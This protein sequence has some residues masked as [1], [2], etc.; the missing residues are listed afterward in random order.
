MA[1]PPIFQQSWS[2][3]ANKLFRVGTFE[4]NRWKKKK[5]T[6]EGK[7]ALCREYTVELQRERNCSFKS[8][9]LVRKLDLIRSLSRFFL[10][11][12]SRTSTVYLTLTEKCAQR[13][14]NFP[15]CAGNGRRTAISFVASGK[16]LLHFFSCS[17][18][19]QATTPFT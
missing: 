9:R 6:G 18:E 8:F 14:S 2:R 17:V 15:I 4:E 7:H 16:A 1:C 5:N 12:P 13:A 11:R 10:F 3:S 19:L